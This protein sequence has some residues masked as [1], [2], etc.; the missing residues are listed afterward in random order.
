[1]KDAIVRISRKELKSKKG[2]FDYVSL[3]G[4]M[5]DVHLVV[6]YRSVRVKAG[7]KFVKEINYPLMFIEKIEKC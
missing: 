7:M 4:N 1:M 3:S 5:L 2:E 6:E